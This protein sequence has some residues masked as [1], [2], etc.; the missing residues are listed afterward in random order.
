MPIVRVSPKVVVRCRS[1][2]ASHLKFGTNPQR[3]P[4]R[5]GEPLPLKPQKFC[6][7]HRV[8]I[9]KPGMTK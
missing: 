2:S 1:I 4:Q 5:C 9:T 6:N 7:I 3:L 8:E